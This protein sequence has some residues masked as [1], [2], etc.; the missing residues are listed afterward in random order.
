M[1]IEG[2]NYR[3]RLHG[4]TALVTAAGQGMGRAGALA[5]AREGA[6]VI[7]TDRDEAL[8][9]SLQGVDGIQTMALDVLDPAAVRSTV[10]QIGAVNI[11]FNCAGWVHQGTILECTENDWDRSFDLNVR[12][13]FITTK[14]II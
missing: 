9:A 13:M 11:L 2:S 12:A 4:K 3:Q 14:A 10:D 6:R 7:A 1:T 8:L 5:F